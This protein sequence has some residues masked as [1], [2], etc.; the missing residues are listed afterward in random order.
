MPRPT[1]IIKDQILGML[2]EV[3]LC[4][5]YAP[6]KHER[7]SIQYGNEANTIRRASIDVDIW[8]TRKGANLHDGLIRLIRDYFSRDRLI[9][10][11]T[12]AAAMKQALQANSLVDSFV[13]GLTEKI[14]QDVPLFHCFSQHTPP[15]VAD[16]LFCAI[17]QSIE[18]STAN[19]LF[20]YPLQRLQF[21]T[22]RFVS[23]KIAL[24]AAT[25]IST[26]REYCQVHPY[27]RYL[28]PAA[29]RYFGGAFPFREAK[30]RGWLLMSSNGISSLAFEM[31]RRRA[32]VFLGVTISAIAES[33][34]VHAFAQ[35]AADTDDHAASFND[36]AESNMRWEHCGVMLHSVLGTIQF[37][38]AMGYRIEGWYAARESANV[39]MRKRG[40]VAARFINDAA[41]SSGYKRFLA[42]F[43]SL[44]ALFGARGAVEANIVKGV[45]RCAY[46]SEIDKKCEQ[47][48]ELRSELV[49]GGTASV[50]EWVGYEEYC[51]CFESK[52]EQ[53][54][55][56]IAASCLL[57][58][59]QHGP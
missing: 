7:L 50:E 49:H 56:M 44:D 52:P 48:F 17:D 40:T 10:D 8:F 45:R 54:I 18:R 5:F 13:D 4:Y 39:E 2:R 11:A 28:D 20:V 1:R 38:E 25:D 27:L 15:Q 57:N 3:R 6:A 29:E 51:D 16:A 24:V 42:F 55:E 53:D 37:T 36:C 58:Y 9:D 30:E 43:F 47:L 32:T 22:Q 23:D 31:S 14:S 19:W 41:V 33:I 12:A 34:G 59:F 46:E 21:A 35:S 26:W